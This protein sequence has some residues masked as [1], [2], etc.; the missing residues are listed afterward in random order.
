MGETD[1]GR[2]H[3]CT[4]CEAPFYDMRRTPITCP[5]CGATHQPVALLKSDGRPPRRNRL[6]PT[7]A[8]TAP[9]ETEEKAAPDDSEAPDDDAH[10][11]EDED[12][13]ADDEVT[14]VD[15]ESGR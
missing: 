9:A 10:E 1:R 15:A 11:H 2:K 3:V 13:D 4:Q 14:A 12:Q 6:R 8:A 7:I 5:K